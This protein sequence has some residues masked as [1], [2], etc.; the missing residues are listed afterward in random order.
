MT[1][2]YKLFGG[3]I[4]P[5]SVKI[6]SYFR[7]KEI[8]YSWIIRGP[9]NEKVFQKYSK[10]PIIPLVISPNKEGIQDST[11]IMDKL[12]QLHTNK[13]IVPDDP[14]LAFLSFLLE[15]YADEWGNKH[16]FQ[17]RWK[18]EIDQN[19]ASARIAEMNLPSYIKYIPII[20]T[21]I[22]YRISNL[23]KN[24]MSKR[25]WVIGS[26][27]STENQ[28]SESF[29]NVLSLM[30]KH[31]KDRPFI[32]GKKPSYADFGLWGQIY[33][34]WTDPT[35]RNM[36]EQKYSGLL[37]WIQRMLNP[38]EE[39]PYESWDL[40]S[41]TLMPI[42]KEE[43]AN[44]FL[45]WTEAI[46]AG[47]RSNKKEISIKLN[48]KRF[49]HSLGGPQKYHVK[50]LAALKHRYM[51]LEDKTSLDKILVDAGIKEFFE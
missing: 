44:T 6:R 23:I 40:L 1:K 48:G 22:K 51:I 43:I 36:I 45:P 28:I 13:S 49:M 4:S 31:L 34:S 39:G 15:E 12:E 35:P 29:M 25:L 17:Y 42:L 38:K 30:Q 14:S 27:K 7:Y 16:M 5:Y 19:S 20:N 11:V 3:E 46:T 24:R 41:P 47:I 18:A 26:N 50:S 37:P 8:P 21:I 2:K 32:F 9:S 10:L 33:N